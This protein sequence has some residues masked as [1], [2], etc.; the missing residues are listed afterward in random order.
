MTNS[1]DK[2]AVEEIAK[3]R[4]NIDPNVDPFVVKGKD[5]KTVHLTPDKKK[6]EDFDKG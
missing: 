6:G 5:G 1:D 3:A 4:E 2:D